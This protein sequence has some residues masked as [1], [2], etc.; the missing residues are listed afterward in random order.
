MSRSVMYPAQRQRLSG[1]DEAGMLAAHY[2]AA[3]FFGRRP[4]TERKTVCA[5]FTTAGFGGATGTGA[6][7]SAESMATAIARHTATKARSMASLAREMLLGGALG[8]SLSGSS[9]RATSV[10]GVDSTASGSTGAASGFA[11]VGLVRS[12]NV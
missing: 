12:V 10:T 11:F 9:L 1:I 7:S 3:P 8:A 2:G 6:G 4:F 5:A